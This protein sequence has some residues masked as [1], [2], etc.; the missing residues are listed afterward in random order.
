MAIVF[1]LIN[2]EAGAEERILATLQALEVVTE[3]SI[4]HGVYD[5]IAKLEAPSMD[6]IKA[7]IFKQIRNLPEVRS[8]LTMVVVESS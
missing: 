6:L 7:V 1:L 2:S 8:T 4:V 5:I 3:A